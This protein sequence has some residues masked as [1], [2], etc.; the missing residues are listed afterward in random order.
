[1]KDQLDH[2]ARFLFVILFGLSMDY[3]V[4]QGQSPI[5]RRV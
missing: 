3:H 4:H 5:R 2:L 1:M